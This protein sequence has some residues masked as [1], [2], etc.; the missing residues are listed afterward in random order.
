MTAPVVPLRP[1]A[2]VAA[3]SRDALAA[4]EVHLGRCALAANTV[5]AYRRQARAFVTW[6]TDDADGV[7][8]A[9]P[10]AFADVVGAEAA[11]TAWRRH[12][13]TRRASPAT[14]NQGLAAV[15]LMYTQAG[16]RIDVKPA[17]LPKPGEPDAL[18]RTEQGRL[19]RAAARRTA[20]D[21]AIIAVLLYGGARVEECARLETVDVTLTA[22]TGHARLHGKGDEVRTVPLPSMAREHL[23]AW[24]DERGPQ[25]GPLWPGQ[26]GPLSVSGITQ[27]VLAVGDDAGLPG[28]RPHRL[29]HTYATRLREGGADPAQIQALLGHS[30][31]ET[32]AR[33]FRAGAAEQAAVVNQIFEP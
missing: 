15:T 22:R 12:L 21:R 4:V 2:G 30:S 6:L 3:A 19:E 32:S 9:H 27:V 29:R 16:L 7:H 26:R 5:K 17:R 28:L 8:G 25:A 13:L 20:R 18:T 33:Y 14:V 10:D 11:V 23:A 1:A 31:V 24:L